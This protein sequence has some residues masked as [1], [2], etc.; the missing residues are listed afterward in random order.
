MTIGI[1]HNEICKNTII[2]RPEDNKLEVRIEVNC[3]W[4]NKKHIFKLKEVSY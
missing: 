4:C 2:R 1:Y 3:A